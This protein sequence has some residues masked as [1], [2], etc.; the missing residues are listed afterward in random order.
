VQGQTRRLVVIRHSKA[1]QTGESDAARELTRR[2]ADDAAAAGAWLAGQ[3]LAPDHVLVS[4]SVRTRQTWAALS[5]GAGWEVGARFDDGLYEAGPETALDLIR[6]TPSA[7]AT[8]VVIGHNP[9]M[10]HL[11][12]MLDDG[13]G[14]ADAGAEMATGFP[15]SAVAVFEYDGEWRDLDITGARLV[16]FHVGRG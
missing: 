3:D 16:G 7:A 13:S 9:T 8:L 2:G 11:A 15:T 6:E 10:G 12:Q 4:D 14:D 1:E 5:G